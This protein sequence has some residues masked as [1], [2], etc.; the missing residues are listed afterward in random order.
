ML[1]FLAA[2]CI[3]ACGAR[4][5]LERPLVVPPDAALE[6]GSRADAGCDVG[7]RV[8]GDV[9]GAAL[10]F[11]GGANLPAGRYRVVYVD[12]CMKYSTGQAWSV[13]AYGAGAS[14]EL[15]RWWLTGNRVR[16]ATMPGTVGF[17]LGSGG[18][19]TFEQCVASNLSVAPIEID[20]DGGVLGVAL[21]DDP[22]RDNVM[23]VGGRSPSW[24]LEC[25]P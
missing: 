4:T 25:V 9:F 24:A 1:G 14:A 22:Y 18:F 2:G 5:D 19:A 6:A 10:D 17:D 3:A 11:A 23:G 16:L 12:G 15:P 7:G 21:G 8:V 20:F 13:N